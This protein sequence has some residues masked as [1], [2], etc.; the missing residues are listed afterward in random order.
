MGIPDPASQ[1][2]PPPGRVTIARQDRPLGALEVPMRF[3]A[4]SLTIA[5]LA[6][7]VATAP[8]WARKYPGIDVGFPE[9]ITVEGDTLKLNGLG[10]R[11]ATMLKVDVYV[12]GLYVANPSKEAAALLAAG[13][14]KAIHLHF[15]RKVGGADM[16]KAWT[17]GFAK[18]GA[19][20]EMKPRL[21]KLN[22]WMK[23][24]DAGSTLRFTWLKDG[25][26]K[27]EADGKE[28]GRIEGED[29]SR[30]L[31]T[32]FLGPNPPNPGLK[33]GLLGGA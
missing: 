14:P 17:E 11:E 10:L 31:Y 30:M 3:C 7:A 13:G 16:V 20:T 18:N 6:Q 23:D 32:V 9:T 22:G 4:R 5:V 29:F 21:D 15:V 25:S 27:V 2:E 26:T 28:L 19:P 8:A 1:P 12:A 24:V 33:T